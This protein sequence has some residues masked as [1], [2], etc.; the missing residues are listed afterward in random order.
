MSDRAKIESLY[1]VE[2]L[3][4]YWRVCTR[5]IRRLIKNGELAVVRI[6]SRVLIPESSIKAVLAA[7]R[8]NKSRRGG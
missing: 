8:T 4:E 6:G 1:T 3:A 5:T 7:G 2:E